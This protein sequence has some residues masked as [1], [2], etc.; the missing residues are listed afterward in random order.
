M[1]IKKTKM[2]YVQILFACAAF[3]LIIL[4]NSIS[5]SNI[6]EKK[7]FEAVTVALD[8]TEK[9]IYAYLREPSVAFVIVYNT[10]T[11]ML[12]KGESQEAIHSYLAQTTSL[13]KS[14]GGVV[15]LTNVYGHIRG[16]LMLGF[17]IELEDNY[18]PQ[19]SPW[20]QL[21]I[22][23]DEIEYTAPYIDTNT[24][25]TVIS[26][27]QRIFGK[28]GDYYGVLALDIETA[29]LM[30]YSESLQFTEGGYGMIVNQFLNIIAHPLEQ[31][32]NAQL[33]TVSEDF[34]EIADILRSGKEV[35]AVIA[36]DN[37]G[38]KSIVFF[39]QLYNGWHVGVV[40]PVSSYNSDLYSSVVWMLALAAVLVVLSYILLRLSAAKV[41]FEK[42]SEFKSTFLATTSHEI[43]TPINA[44]IGISQ[45]Q[46]QKE[47]LPKDC[48]YAFESIY[49][50]GNVLVGI[51][52]DILDI[53]KIETG[54]LDLNPAEYSV[55]ALINSTVKLNVV[56]IGSKPIE[57]KLELDETLPL[58]LLGDELRLKQIL[59][60]LLSNAVK[61][62]ERG[63]IRMSVSHSIEGD[64][65]RLCFVVEDTGQGMKQ[66][67]CAKMFTKYQRFNAEANKATEG[68]GLG[69]SITKSIT[70]MMGGEINFE[71]EY[72]KGS[73]FTVE[74][75][76][77]SAGD[78]VIG[79]QTAEQ[80]RTFS[81]TGGNKNV[82]IIH[83]PMPYGRVLVVDDLEIN[84]Y[85]AEGL[86]SPYMLQV[87]TA[88][89]G[90]CAI[91][92]VENGQ[93]YDVIF[94]D[95]M[96]PEMDG[97][98][99]TQVIRSLG[100]KGVIIAFTANALVGNSDMF[101]KNGFDGFMPKPIDAVCLN[102]VLNQHVR[103]K[104]PDKALKISH[105]L[106]DTMPCAPQFEAEK[107][108]NTNSIT[109][110]GT[111]PE[112]LDIFKGDA[113]K[114]ILTLDEAFKSGDIKLFS[115]TAHGM[116]SALATVGEAQSSKL[117]FELEQAGINGE[118]EYIRANK[119]EFINILKALI[120]EL[121]AES[122]K[123]APG[124]GTPKSA[125]EVAEIKERLEQLK[126]ACEDYDDTAAYKI[127]EQLKELHLDEEAEATIKNIR[128]MLFLHSNFE[129]ASALL[130]HLI[131]SF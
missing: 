94:M 66:E 35:S 123:A 102:E 48:A 39:Q 2:T 30:E 31:Y 121:T 130:N 50:S 129:G 127:V 77:K 111:D 96:M 89:D 95:H 104:N 82:Q 4:I 22:R 70:A 65:V 59:N 108:E 122:S 99:T 115:T 126:A 32:Q 44:I 114:A 101:K 75:M 93:I 106:P 112:L 128:R 21:A 23:S 6:I 55:P 5:V 78:A 33:Y 113:E 15:G 73:K 105:I 74:V 51:V 110:R 100:Y 72:G 12:D 119:D 8:E 56:R 90:Y 83:E 62:T 92:K 109:Q 19:R 131:Q 52:N 40:M 16:E 61:Y 9:T 117:A 60:N 10:V 3:F 36:R 41:Q 57:F 27:A 80:L 14:E 71:S 116:K 13:L 42:E 17:D 125:A 76:Q 63:H 64:D 54:K 68:A 49:N 103:D 11:D 18:I 53:S 81:F 28:N 20:Y 84:L 85:V 107:S 91:K 97:I 43:R 69:L 1:S 124:A 25:N 46:L 24:G 58:M 7:S 45:I 29:W 87:E 118:L 34:A 47:S 37:A 26:L 67:D 79:A 86:L 98:E 88:T 120:K 38:T